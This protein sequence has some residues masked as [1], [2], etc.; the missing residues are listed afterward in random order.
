MLENF[1]ASTAFSF[2]SQTEHQFLVHWE[3]RDVVELDDTVIKL[4]LT[5]DMKR[6][7]EHI[8]TLKTHVEA[9]RALAAVD[10]LHDTPRNPLKPAETLNPKT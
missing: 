6:H 2:L 10:T 4:V 5:T 7:F 1:H 3:E 9:A 8:R